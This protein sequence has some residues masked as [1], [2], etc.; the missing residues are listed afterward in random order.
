MSAHNILITLKLML[1]GGIDIDKDVTCEC[2]QYFDHLGGQSVGRL[3]V[4]TPT[5]S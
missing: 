3:G 1:P 2:S 4:E 5:T